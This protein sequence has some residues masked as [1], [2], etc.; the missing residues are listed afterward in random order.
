[1]SNDKGSFE[2]NDPNRDCMCGGG[3]GGVSGLVVLGLE[4]SLC[5]TQ[6]DDDG[7]SAWL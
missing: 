1:M 7:G 2:R 3:G 5:C 4:Y 6:H